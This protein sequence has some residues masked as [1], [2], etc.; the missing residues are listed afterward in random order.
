MRYNLIMIILFLAGCTAS[1][2]YSSEEEKL[3]YDKC[4]GCHRVYSKSEINS[5]KVKNDIDGMSKKA[6]LNGAEKKMII[7]YL[8]NRQAVK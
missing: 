8:S 3:Y 2:V 7:E 6:R 4:G 1:I 5:G